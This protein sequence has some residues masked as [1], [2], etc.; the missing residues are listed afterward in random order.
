MTTKQA[1]KQLGENPTKLYHHVAALENAGLVRLRETRQKRG[2]T[3]KYYETVT[4]RLHASPDAIAGHT[5]RDRAAMGMVVF[6]ESRNELIQALAAGHADGSLPLIATR[7]I[8]RLSPAGAR[9]V[10]SELRR[11]LRR[12]APRPRKSRSA[13]TKPGKMLRYSL[14]IALIPRA[15]D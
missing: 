10:A 3:E 11:V 2:A 4:R 14:T 6:D 13:K 8:M 9:K 12:V 7:A 5:A 15:D 1:A